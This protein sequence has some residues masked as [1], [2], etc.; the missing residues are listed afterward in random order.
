MVSLSAHA[1]LDGRLASADCATRAFCWL[2]V[3]VLGAGAFGPE[4]GRDSWQALH[5]RALNSNGSLGRLGLLSLE[6]QGGDQS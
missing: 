6:S 4:Q 5:R 2:L 1:V 3:S